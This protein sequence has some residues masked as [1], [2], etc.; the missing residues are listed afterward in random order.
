MDNKT[1][2]GSLRRSTTGITRREFALGSVAALASVSI[3]GAP[4]KGYGAGKNPV[5]F[6]SFGGYFNDAIQTTLIDAFTK[7]T[8]IGVRMASNTSLASLKGQINANAVQWDIAELTGSEYEI[9]IQQGIPLEPLDFNIIQT[10][11]IPDY[12]IKDYGIK[13]AYFMAV[14]A[15]DKRVIQ[16]PPETWKQFFDPEQFP[17]RRSLYATL[18]DSMLLEFALIADGVAI[19]SLYPLDVDRALG[20]LSKLKSDQILWHTTNQQVIQQLQ[21]G[22]SQ[23]AMPFTGRI[24]LANQGGASIGY[25]P[26]GGGATGDYLVVPKGANNKEN[27]MKLID[28]ICNDAQAGAAFMR[29]TY[30][31][32]TNL[33]AIELLED[34]VADEMPTSPALEEKIFRKDDTWWAENLDAVTQKFKAWQIS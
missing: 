22:E 23:L 7:S 28:F 12:A 9:A 11:N 30:Y 3:A 19:D 5:T 26:N 24:R 16:A 13:Y 15:W 6:A 17:Q 14:M 10:D 4:L 32:L 31:G 8:G 25:T 33:K 27:A 1:S 2:T 34:K 29:K 20:V 21:S 18:S